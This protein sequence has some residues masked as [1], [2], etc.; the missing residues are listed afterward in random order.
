MEVSATY[1]KSVSIDF[2]SVQPIAM[3]MYMCGLFN[4]EGLYAIHVAVVL[5]AIPFAHRYDNC[6]TNKLINVSKLAPL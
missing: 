6:F 2:E 5:S 4:G 1:N 3:R